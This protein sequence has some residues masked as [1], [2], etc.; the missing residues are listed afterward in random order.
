[1][2]PVLHLPEDHNL[3]D[4][5]PEDRH[6]PEDYDSSSAPQSFSLGTPSPER[7]Y[8]VVLVTAPSEAV[9]VALAHA[10]V[11]QQWA[12][13]VS[14]APITSVYTWQGQIQ[15]EPEWQ[16][17]IKTQQ[18]HYAALE[19]QIQRLHPYEVPEIIALP[20]IAGAANYLHWLGE[21]TQQP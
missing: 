16:L 19:Q 6:N 8:C 12:A 21:Q 15:Q 5:N 1:M 20:I 3:E 7:K 17:L 9:A 2:P 18:A 4:H 11:Q 10:L 14:L 13:C